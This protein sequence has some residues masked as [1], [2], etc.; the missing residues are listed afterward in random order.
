[1]MV[2]KVQSLK[3]VLNQQYPQFVDERAISKRCSIV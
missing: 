3:Q 1:M 2:N